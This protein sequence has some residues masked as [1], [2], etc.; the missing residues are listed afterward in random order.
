MAQSQLSTIETTFEI[1]EYL[2]VVQSASPSEISDELDV[3]L[4]T[5]HSYLS[6]LKGLE[7]LVNENGI[8]SISAAMLGIG[9]R[10]REKMDLYDAGESVVEDLAS[11]VEEQAT[12][13]TIENDQPV[14]VYNVNKNE[15][16][17]LK[18]HPG[19][20]LPHHAT[21]SGKLALAFTDVS[22]DDIGTLEEYTKKTITDREEVAKQ[23]EKA[24]SEEVS[25]AYEEFKPKL[26]AIAVPIFTEN[27]LSGTLSVV[28]P[29]KQM[30]QSS[31]QESVIKKLQ[32]ASNT[33]E[34]N[35]QN[36]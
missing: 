13:T 30:T 5:V 3:P 15:N 27:E 22:I 8:Y 29:L 20:M 2:S 10:T 33:I 32:T 1:L 35:L 9:E 34:V 25:F 16:M 24:R 28:G 18:M 7:Y 19:M 21:V 12:L 6:T 23:V 4:S 26:M 11:K 36:Q 14:V 31:V 17:T